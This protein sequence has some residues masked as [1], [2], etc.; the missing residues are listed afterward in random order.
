MG[1]W[2]DG[3]M[4]RWTNRDLG[5]QADRQNGRQKHIHIYVDE[6]VSFQQVRIGSCHVDH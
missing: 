5:R 2:W 4:D 3:R 6:S 1:G